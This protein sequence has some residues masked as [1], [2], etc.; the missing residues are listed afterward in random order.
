MVPLNKKKKKQRT[1]AWF[2]HSLCICLILE[3]H[4]DI[5]LTMTVI[6]GSWLVYWEIQHIYCTNAGVNHL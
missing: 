6:L 4:I 5:A 3:N 1:I 2:T